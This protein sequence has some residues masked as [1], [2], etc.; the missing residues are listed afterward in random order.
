MLETVLI[1]LAGAVVV[2]AIL[3]VMVALQ[4]AEF[5]LSR[6]TTIAAPPAE[7]FAQV[8]DFHHWGSWSPWAKLDPSMKTTFDGPPAGEGAVYSWS[9]NN[10]VGE[11]RMT[12]ITSKPAELIR[13]TLEFFRP[14]KATNLT[15][16]TFQPEGQGT[17]VTWTM[18]GTNNFMAKAFH[19]IMNMEKL[20]GPD[21][22]KGLAQLKAVVE[23]AK[24]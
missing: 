20:V 19:L 21:F 3:C 23:Q 10:K 22:E 6:S 8:N 5:K 14:W 18:T 1:I 11:G 24:K 4:P 12:L 15:E 17:R 16:F 7:P 2:I 9:G 13:I